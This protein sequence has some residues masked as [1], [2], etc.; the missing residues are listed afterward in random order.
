MEWK[1]VCLVPRP[2]TPKNG[3]IMDPLPLGCNGGGGV[4]VSINWK[5][6]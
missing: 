6:A 5:N 1:G 3:G 2:A 4:K